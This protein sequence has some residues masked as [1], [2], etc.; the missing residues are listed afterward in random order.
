MHPFG[1]LVFGCL[2]VF[3]LCMIAR[4]IR[5]GHISTRDAEFDLDEQPIR[6]ALVLVFQLFVLAFCIWCAVGY[7]P[8]AFFEAIG[9]STN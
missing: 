1:Q 7:E 9:F 6:F 3:A 4:A 8:A 5:K 2:A